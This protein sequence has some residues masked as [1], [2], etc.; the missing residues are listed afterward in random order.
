M[1]RW[2]ETNVGADLAPAI[3]GLDFMD[4]TPSRVERGTTSNATEQAIQYDARNG[5]VHFTW[6]WVHLPS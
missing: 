1:V 6:H 3:I 4:Y 5:V 2:I